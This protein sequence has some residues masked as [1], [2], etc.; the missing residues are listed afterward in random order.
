ME[1][2]SGMFLKIGRW[3][4]ANVMVTALISLAASVAYQFVNPF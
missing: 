3:L 1:Q 4:Q 2:A